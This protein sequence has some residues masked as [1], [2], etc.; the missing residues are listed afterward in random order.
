MKIS[1][2]NLFLENLVF[3]AK[4]HIPFSFKPYYIPSHSLQQQGGNYISGFTVGNP[5][6]DLIMISHQMTHFFLVGLIQNEFGI[7]KIFLCGCRPFWIK[8]KFWEIWV[9]SS[10]SS[11][12]C[13]C[14][15]RYF[16]VQSIQASNEIFGA[17]LRLHLQG[18]RTMWNV[19]IEKLERGFA[20]LERMYLSIGAEW[21][22]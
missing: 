8:D 13:G 14:L 9:G 18:E 15:V 19:V 16:G 1:L 20:G 10:R 5:L 6:D 12:K 17:S 7:W 11:V 21:R 4:V 2:W 22:L 3:F